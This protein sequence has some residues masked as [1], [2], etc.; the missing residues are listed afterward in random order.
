MSLEQRKRQKVEKAPDASAEDDE[1]HVGSAEVE[2]DRKSAGQDVELQRNSDGDAFFELSSTRRISIRKFKG[3]T[4]VDIREVR[5]IL[6]V[7]IGHSRPLYRVRMLIIFYR[8]L[9][10]S[11]QFYEKGGKT[12]PGKKGIS[13]TLEQYETLRDVMLGGQVDKEIKTLE[14]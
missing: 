11:T 12:L 14:G 6:S 7:A 1:K 10:M 13:L 9:P 2:M 3:T 5:G 8:Y 4:L